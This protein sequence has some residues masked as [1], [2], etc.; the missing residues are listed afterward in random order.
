[1]SDN[2][3]G[4]APPVRTFDVVPIVISKYS[5]LRNLPTADD[6][7]DRIAAILSRWGGRLCPWDVPSDKRSVASALARLESWSQPKMSRCSVL[8]WI[9]HGSSN[10]DVAVV[11]LPA[12]EIDIGLVPHQ[13]AWYIA[14]EDRMREAPDWTIVIIESCGGIRFAETIQSEIARLRVRDGILLIGVGE[15]R[16]EGYLGTFRR[17]LE[18]VREVYWSNDKV[19]S[20][21]DLADQLEEVLDPGFVRPMGLFGRSTLMTRPDLTP[22][23]TTS[24]DFYPELKDVLAELPESDLE[25]LTVVGQKTD[26]LEIGGHFVGRFSERSGVV[27]WLETHSSGMFVVTGAAGSGKSALLANLMLHT[28]PPLRSV[29]EHAPNLEE[30]WTDERRIPPVDSALLLI[31]ATTNDVVTRLSTVAAVDIPADL[32]PPKR[33]GELVRVLAERRIPLTLFADA[34]DEARDPV[35]IATLLAQL[36]KLP[37]IRIVLATRPLSRS[38][39]DGDDLLALLRP[40]SELDSDV[41]VLELDDDRAAILKFATARLSS[42]AAGVSSLDLLEVLGDIERSASGTAV[43]AGWD[44]LRARLVVT[45]L[46]ATPELLTG[47]FAADRRRMMTLDHIGLFHR[48]LH[49]LV[50]AHPHAEPLLLALAYGNGRGLPRA[51]RI[52][53]TVAKVF[54]PGQTLTEADITRILRDAGPYIMLDAEDG[55]SVFRLVHRTFTDELLAR[56]DPETRMAVLRALIDLAREVPDPAPYLRRYLS[57][58]ASASGRQGWSALGE[59]PEVLDMLDLP[60]LLADS[61]RLAPHELPRSV[62]ALRRTAHLAL[63][64]TDG[65]R[66]GYR[67]FGL[68]QETGHHSET[69]E[70]GSG[71]AWQ[72]TRARLLRHPSHQTN[73]LGPS[74]PVRSLAVCTTADGAVI[75]YG[76][77]HGRLC[78]WNPWQGSTVD[79]TPHIDRAGEILALAAM[80]GAHGLRLASVGAAQPIRL[81]P[82]AEDLEPTEL[83]GGDGGVGCAIEACRLENGT[84]LLAVG[85]T[86]GRLR[87]SSANPDDVRGADRPKVLAG[88]AGRITGL[89]TV[90]RAAGRELVSVSFDRSVRRWSLPHGRRLRK[91]QWRTPLESMAVAEKAGLILTG[92]SEGVVAVWNAYTL[93]SLS[94]FAAHDGPVKA[95][96]VLQDDADRLVFASGG[97]DRRVRL[98]CTTSGDPMGPDLTGHDDEITDLVTLRSPDG[99]PFVASGSRDGKVKLWT[100]TTPDSTPAPRVNGRSRHEPPERWDLVTSEAHAVTITRT[101]SGQL[102]CHLA[103]NP[104]V[105]LPSAANHARCVAVLIDG[106]SAVVATSGSNVIHTWQAETGEIACPPLDGHRDWVRALLPLPLDDGRTILVSGG[107]DG[108]VCLWDLRSGELRHHMDF[109]SAVQALAHVDGTRRFTVTLGDGEI[110]IEVEDHVLHGH[111]KGNCT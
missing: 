93:C 19:I 81:W 94:H 88:H 71:A 33:A 32:T 60:T 111:A 43:D 97:V 30:R 78:L 79:L 99:T 47:A 73:S 34:L 56:L 5:R 8:L 13:L 110:D 28:I 65:D 42:A 104:E 50:S 46:L 7:A 54:A 67:Q 16:G 49:R 23:V 87:V 59:T 64:G 74:I 36:A 77:D 95:L 58:H 92:D 109:G 69:V 39:V 63:A 102:K 51:D 41:S 75:A 25:R 80:D 98:W 57:G 89:A 4:S 37:R 24:V 22:D 84:T 68:A 83:P 72:I 1:M 82:L 103:P 62:L 55:R 108:R 9:S 101:P 66:R 96:A 86:L 17:A 85:T 107:G 26:L 20:L 15:D 31:G 29:L 106:D 105:I 91:G 40:I 48:A 11:H 10:D 52:W 3:A 35:E 90:A 2:L 45:E 70:P 53:I 27:A 38:G 18:E 76:N 12:D 14:R 61:W 44:F 100:P 6:E 21:R